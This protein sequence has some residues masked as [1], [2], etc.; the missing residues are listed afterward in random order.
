MQ[1]IYQLIEAFASGCII[2]QLSFPRS[3]WCY[4]Q[5]LSTHSHGV[6]STAEGNLCTPESSTLF[7]C[8]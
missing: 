4:H 8:C 7:C 3:P 2:S 1:L 6:S 5:Q